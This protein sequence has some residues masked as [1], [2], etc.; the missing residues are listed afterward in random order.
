MSAFLSFPYRDALAYAAFLLVLLFVTRPA[1]LAFRRKRSGYG[2]VFNSVT[3]IPEPLVSVRLKDLHGQVV[4]TAVTDRVGRYRLLAHKGEY[5]VDVTKAGFAF[6]SAYLGKGRHSTVYD[7]LLPTRHVIVQDHGVITKNIPIDPVADAGRSRIFRWRP[8]LGKNTQVA[9]GFLGPVAAF[10]IPWFLMK[11]SVA[12]WAAFVVYAA[13]SLKRLLSFKPAAPPFGAIRDAQTGRPLERAV[14]RIFDASNNKV[15]E[16]QVTSPKG[17]YAFMVR[18]GAYYVV[19]QKPGYRS[20]RL[21]FPRIAK[22]GFLL[23]RDVP[24]RQLGTSEKD[25]LAEKYGGMS[26]P[27]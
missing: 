26:V 3:G 6:P 11:T 20:V 19:V 16:T 23:V 4:G 13:V 8:H 22:D 18:H 15:L 5:I 25:P 14:V 2:A 9:I 12:A 17:R 24:V 27:D 7:N 10:V 1:Y 21:N